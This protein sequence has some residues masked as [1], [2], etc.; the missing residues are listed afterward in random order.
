MFLFLRMPIN[1]TEQCLE[2]NELG[3]HKKGVLVSIQLCQ[4]T[5]NLNAQSNLPRGTGW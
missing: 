2:G 4:V 3:K 5:H 1:T